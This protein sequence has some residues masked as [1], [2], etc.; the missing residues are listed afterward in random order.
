MVVIEHQL[1][2]IKCADQVIDLGPEG[3]AGGGQLVAC[4]T[5][6]EIAL[7]PGSATG[8]CLVERPMLGGDLGK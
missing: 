8:R 7:V 1:D 2:V 5:P 6:E 3:G 4:G